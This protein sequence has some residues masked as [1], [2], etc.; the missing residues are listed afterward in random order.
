M[1]EYSAAS[2]AAGPGNSQDGA[3]AEA[4]GTGSGTIR[5]AS[6]RKWPWP[7]RLL[8]T[9]ALMPVGAAV[10]LTSENSFT[11][12]IGLFFAPLMVALSGAIVIVTWLATGRRQR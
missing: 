10:I 2:P 8:V 3:T 7:A 1:S 5:P 12:A 11:S 6:D 4:D 9:L